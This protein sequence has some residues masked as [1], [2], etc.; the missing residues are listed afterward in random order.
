MVVELSRGCGCLYFYGA[1]KHAKSHRTRIVRKIVKN[2]LDKV[3]VTY[4][5]FNCVT[6]RR[7]KETR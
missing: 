2:I 3:A 7:K 4:E 1:F 5:Y 6:F